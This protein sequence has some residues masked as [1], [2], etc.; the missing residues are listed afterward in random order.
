MNKKT[1]IRP[2]CKCRNLD[3]MMP[4]LMAG[5]GIPGDDGIGQAKQ[6]GF[7]DNSSLNIWSS[8]QPSATST[9]VEHDE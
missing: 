3:P 4:E 6:R 2:V 5:S 1:Y 8:D 9:K 7:M